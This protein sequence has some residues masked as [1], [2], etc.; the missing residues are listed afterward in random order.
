MAHAIPFNSHLTEHI[1]NMRRHYEPNMSEDFLASKH[2][3]HWHHDPWIP[4]KHQDLP[5]LDVHLLAG[6]LTAFRF[7]NIVRH[8]IFTVN[9]TNNSGRTKKRILS[10]FFEGMCCGGSRCFLLENQIQQWFF[11]CPRIRQSPILHVEGHP[12]GRWHSINVHFKHANLLAV[13]DTTYAYLVEMLQTCFLANP[14][15]TDASCLQKSTKANNISDYSFIFIN[16]M[17]LAASNFWF[18]VAFESLC[19][20]PWDCFCP[21]AVLPHWSYWFLIF[22]LYRRELYQY[23][24]DARPGSAKLQASLLSI[25]PQRFIEIVGFPVPPIKLS[26]TLAVNSWGGISRS[27]GTSKARTKDWNFIGTFSQYFTGI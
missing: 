19:F 25:V 11:L 27:M 20:C 2:W 5:L 10:P 3:H 15:L 7:P 16:E 6:C 9:K 23:S 8:A 13:G 18:Q 12:H 4:S 1:R 21:F 22:G 14:N 17:H 26:E 24:Q